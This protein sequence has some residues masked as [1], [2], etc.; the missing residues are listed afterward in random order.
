MGR[1]VSPLVHGTACEADSDDVYATVDL[2][3]ARE[4]HGVLQV[5]AHAHWPVAGWLIHFLT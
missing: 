2:P 4:R 1:A 3:Q 5:S